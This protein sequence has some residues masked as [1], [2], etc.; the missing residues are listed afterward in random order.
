M[1]WCMAIISM[2]PALQD[3]GEGLR[4]GILSTADG[5]QLS[6]FRA[7][8]RTERSWLPKGHIPSWEQ[9]WVQCLLAQGCKNTKT[10]PSCLNLGQ[11]WGVI[12]A[13][14]PPVGS[15]G[16]S[17]WITSQ[18]NCPLYPILLPSFPHRCWPRE[19]SSINLLPANLYLRVGFPG[20][21]TR[22]KWIHTNEFVQ[23]TPPQQECS[24]NAHH[25]VSRP[26]PMVADSGP[27]GDIDWMNQPGHLALEF[28][29]WLS[30]H[31]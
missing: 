29:L 12:H 17:L 28:F 21:L 18:L 30:T 6:P 31:T 10:W 8:L 26:G 3:W 27:S 13:S 1:L 20:N 4:Y 22:D 24:R 16:T 9:P 2:Q 25:D 23:I 11:L 19:H 7:L 5:S 14:K 15:A